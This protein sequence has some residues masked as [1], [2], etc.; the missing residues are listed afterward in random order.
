MALWLTDEQAQAVIRHALTEAPR[1]ACGLIAGHGTRATTIIPAV[2]AAPDPLHYYEIDH[3]ALVQAMITI[4]HSG[5]SLIGIYHSH[6]HGDPIPSH[7]DIIQAAYP[8]AVYLIVGLH[9]GQPRLNGW[10]IRRRE[11]EPVP[12]HIGPY[13]PA[14]ELNPL[15]N[16]QKAAILISA[17]VAFVF[18]IILSLSL[19]PPA[20]TIP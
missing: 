19:L 15:T 6:P 10:R 2:N 1:E 16:P 4:E 3:R 20:P 5:Q 18:M 11:V 8:D 13:P 12:L 14:N 17:I 7:T 9:G